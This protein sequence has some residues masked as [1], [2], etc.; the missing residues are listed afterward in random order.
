MQQKCCYVGLGP[1]LDFWFC[2]L[3][4]QLPRAQEVQAVLVKDGE[5]ALDERVPC[6]VT[7][8]R[9]PVTV[10]RDAFWDLPAQASPTCSGTQLSSAQ[11]LA[12]S[13]EQVQVIVLTPLSVGGRFCSSTQLY[14][15]TCGRSTALQTLMWAPLHIGAETR[16]DKEALPWPVAPVHQRG[17]RFK[18]CS[19][20]MPGFGIQSW[21]GRVRETTAPCFSLPKIN[22]ITSS[23]EGYKETTQ[24]PG[25]RL[26]SEK[27]LEP[28]VPQTE[29]WKM[30]L[31]TPCSHRHCWQDLQ[32][33]LAG[34]AISSRRCRAA[35][36]PRYQVTTW[37]SPLL[38]SGRVLSEMPGFPFSAQPGSSLLTASCSCAQRRT[39]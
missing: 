35:P 24:T 17:C 28:A 7:P 38:L 4:S 36:G 39:E 15:L 2:P 22:P 31:L 11:S 12:I 25:G 9:L 14:R 29:P 16:Y 26:S 34:E 8:Q 5:R 10:L 23:G 37:D 33:G 30:A 1:A 13:H 6:G 32:P 19:G 20:H 27:Q 18:S 21:F 3:G